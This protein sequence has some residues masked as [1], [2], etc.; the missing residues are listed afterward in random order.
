MEA[1]AHN[2]NSLFE[3]LGLSAEQN[4]IEEFIQAHRP[5]PS[6]LALSEAPFWTAAQAAFLREE[7]LKDADWAEV[8]DQLNAE[9][10]G[11]A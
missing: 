3:Q 11:S 5:L 1:P 4:A 2:L 8:I 10:H 6:E 7:M 9:L